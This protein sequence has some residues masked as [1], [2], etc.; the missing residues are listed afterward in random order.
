MALIPLL[1]WVKGLMVRY[2]TTFC[3]FCM[4]NLIS[5]FVSSKFDYSD[6]LF[7]HQMYKG[8]LNDGSYVAIQVLKMKRNYNT[9]TFTRHIEL[10]SKLRHQHLVSVLGHCYEFNLD[11]SSVSRLFLVFEYAPNGTLRDWISG[12]LNKNFK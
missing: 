12:K 8:Q 4:N 6:F 9:H 7:E 10:I 11:D 3:I 2:I 5:C 1:S